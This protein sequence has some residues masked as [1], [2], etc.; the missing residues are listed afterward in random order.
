MTI[1]DNNGGNYTINGSTEFTINPFVIAANDPKLVITLD[2]D[3]D[4]TYDGTAKEP[5]VKKVEYD[6]KKIS[7]DEY[8]VTYSESHTNVGTVTVTI[9]DKENGNYAISGSTQFSIIPATFDPNALT[10]D[11]KPT[12]NKSGDNNL[13]YNGTSQNLVVA[14]KELP[15]GYTIQ[16]KI[17]GT[18][19]EF[20][21]TIPTATN[22][23]SYTVNVLYVGDGNHE[24]FE[25]DAIEV[26][27]DKA[28]I[29]NVVA[30]TA[31]AN[32]VYNGNDQALITAGSA[33][34][35]TMMYSV[36]YNDYQSAIPT[37]KAAGSYTVKYMVKGN[38]NYNDYIPSE[39][40]A[41][42]V[43][44][45]GVFTIKFFNYDGTTQ[46]GDPL[47]VVE[48]DTPV[49]PA[50]A[51]TPTRD[52]D[53]TYTYTF[54]GWSP[55]LAAATGNQDY[56][57]QY[58]STVNC[59]TASAE[60]SELVYTG[61]ERKPTLKVFTK[62]ADTEF[63]LIGDDES[64]EYEVVWPQN[65]TDFGS[66]TAT[67]KGLGVFA[68]CPQQSVTWSITKA[69][70]DTPSDA[71][72][73]AEPE[74]I[75]NK[76][77]GKITGVSDA[78]EYRKSGVDTYTSVA[79]SA[80]EISPLAPGDYY[81]RYKE[82]GNHSA[83]DELMVTVGASNSL[84]TVSFDSKEGTSVSSVSSAYGD[85]ISEPSAPTKT[86]YNFG[87]WY[88]DSNLTT[89]WNFA[90]D[91]VEA[92]I[93]L[94]AKWNVNQYSVTFVF[95]NGKSDLVIKKDFGT[96]ISSLKPS[97]PEWLGHKFTG[98]DKEIPTTIPAE[99][100][101]ITAQWED[102]SKQYV[103]FVTKWD[104][105]TITTY[106][107][108]EAYPGEAIS[109]AAPEDPERT[110]YTFD[111]WSE[112]TFPTVMPDDGLTIY[113]NWSINQYTITFDTDGG[114]AI[115]PIM[116]DYNT[117]ITNKPAD[118]TKPGYT[119]GGWDKAIPDNMPAEDVT[120]T[121]KWSINQYTITFDTDGGT[122]IAPIKQ[123]YNTAITKPK[124]PTKPGYTFDGWNV[125]IPAFMP[126]ADITIKAN[127][128]VNQYTITFDT[129]GGN[130]IDAIT[131]DYNSAI[132]APENPTKEGY[133]FDYW[134][135]DN[136]KT[137]IPATMPAANIT[138]KA[139]WT[140]QKY[141]VTF[142]SNGGS[143]VA[144]VKQEYNLT[145]SA[146]DAPTKEGHT[147]KGWF[148]DDVTFAAPWTFSTDKVTKDITLY[149]KWDVN[150]YKL[151]F[152]TDGGSLVSE[153]EQ[154]F[155]T[156]VTAPNAP[157]KA[158]HSFDYWMVD[159]V[160]A[161]IPTSMP[162]KNITFEAHWSPNTY[163]II[164]HLDNGDPDVV[165]EAKYGAYITAPANFSKENHSFDRWSRTIPATMPA[166]DDPI[167]ITALWIE[168]GKYTVTLLTENDN[169]EEEVVWSSGSFFEDEDVDYTGYADP[170]RT[171]Y[172]F[173]G[174]TTADG[175]A[176]TMPTTMPEGGI[177]L[178]AKWTIKQY[179][180]TYNT[181]GGSAINETNKL[182]RDYN[183]AIPKPSDPTKT[184]NTFK[185][186]YTDEQCE[187]PCDFVAGKV[188][189][190]ITLY[191]KWEV[192]TYTIT[193][194]TKGGSNVPAIE[195]LFNTPITKPGAPTK[196]GYTFDGWS[197]AIPDNMPAKNMT[198]TAN[199]NINQYTITF[200][201]D[202]NGNVVGTITQDY[203]FAV[204][205]SNIKPNKTGYSFSGWKTSV[206]EQMPAENMSIVADWTINQYTITFDTDGGSAIESITL[207]YDTEITAPENPKKDGFE[208]IGWDPVIPATMPVDGIT[209]KAQWEENVA[210]V[211]ES[212]IINGS[213]IYSYNSD[214]TGDVIE[215]TTP[216]DCLGSAVVTITASDNTSTPKVVYA[217]NGVNN[218]YTEPFT[219]DNHGENVIS[220]V[221]T[222]KAGN[223]SAAVTAKVIVHREATLET[224]EYTYTQLSGKDVVLEG[225]DLDGANVSRIT[226]D[227][228]DN[229]NVFNK[230][231]NALDHLILDNVTVGSHTLHLYTD[232]NNEKHDTGIDFSL[233][234]NGFVI[235]TE[236]R[237]DQIS[238]DGFCQGDISVVTLAFLD[239]DCPK[240][241]KIKGVHDKYVPFEDWGSL[242][243]DLG[244]LKFDVSDD[245]QPGTIEFE[246]SF[247]DDPQSNTESEFETIKVKI[248]VSN[249]RI[250]KLF[251]DLLAIDNHDDLFTDFQWYKNGVEI[252]GAT[253]QYYQS[254][255]N[256]SGNYS[257][258]VT[259]TSG[260]HLKVCYVNFSDDGLS[261][262]LKR[263]VNAYP[264]PARAGEEVTLELLNFDETE[265]E[266]CVIK[267]VNNAGA[268][269]ATINN[270]D[271]INTVS[272]PSGTYTGYVIRSGV[273]DKVSFKLIVK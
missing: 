179:T 76:A 266:G 105:N 116:Q 154:I 217:L 200:Y 188:T 52:A 206:P 3:Y 104:D 38:D 39:D 29:T 143:A 175:Q 86:G 119:F 214:N 123:N 46:L 5:T 25:S 256:I 246:V 142:N 87:G 156:E 43:V 263:S 148:A 26:S 184:G 78:M 37:G 48:G 120:I 193:F 23:G 12:A 59:F 22:A 96:D 8:T 14:P 82:D 117:A 70:Y 144:D 33:P 269:V 42:T 20:G 257:A 199:W 133:T 196:E 11:Q 63:A 110:G 45:K 69:K 273:N 131:L 229:T 159:N 77:D 10:A 258:Y 236:Q 224:K 140:T 99:D 212:I 111:G 36:D 204:D 121:A 67:V 220:I 264:N 101:A 255:D 103:K 114:T 157:T 28:N 208:F 146:P 185:G 71:V 44:I 235:T 169:Q 122:A 197:E 126:A 223:S 233:T 55:A 247:T 187:T 4:Y 137:D 163:K 245:F 153:I 259:T 66:K 16:Y 172:T 210:P 182:T 166:S 1:S 51:P 73:A 75:Q 19:G 35:G 202:E 203:Q 109:V 95:G 56:T 34:N 91:K 191:A 250:L 173:Q 152:D 129:D 128:K 232:Y 100:V 150:K 54:S 194:D 89:E 262:S 253:Q 226:I 68:G 81:V 53:K 254:E 271:R 164:F 97:N 168:D 102:E 80:S 228:D 177:M 6:G 151:S 32:L 135:V 21:T 145:I 252:D 270:C 141:T 268:V 147:F 248:N 31:I 272:L 106:K 108:I 136:V 58:T 158:G 170:S 186:W 41:I 261:K 83:S 132:I 222:D 50:T 192:N 189:A 209:V 93:T 165:V 9:K 213:T 227:G 30:P 84:L 85:K 149:A 205:A 112:T 62:P 176:A 60:Q 2:P 125:E 181:N 198:I 230:E 74:T 27:I 107:S 238:A 161:D 124:D 267:I 167:E 219:I 24:S 180:I 195:Q 138:F 160:E 207:D 118:P 201:D 211:I 61:E 134:M 139:K 243:K 92:N 94:Y 13:V 231:I 155:G 215:V 241:Y 239:R 40:A 178:Y 18:E 171:G 130:A 174:W 15:E 127:W 65:V 216:F 72:V 225:L 162:A 190:D 115:A 251:S 79:A 47:S 218:L 113:A 265:Y 7:A 237:E 88:T 240:Y 260:E 221:A 17:D 183:S 242:G 98:W 64:A 234:V 90:S 249:D 57:A 244:Q 49:Y